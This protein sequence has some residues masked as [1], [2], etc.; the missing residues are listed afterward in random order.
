MQPHQQRVV[1][2]KTK[3]VEKLDKLKAA[4]RRFRAT[5]VIL[6]VEV[7]GSPIFKALPADEQ[8][9]MLEYYNILKARIDAYAEFISKRGRRQ[10]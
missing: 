1:D 9:V 2:E 4:T 6:A 7:M 3:L 5:F 8:D 10:K